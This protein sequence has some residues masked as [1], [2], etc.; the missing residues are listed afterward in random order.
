VCLRGSLAR[1]GLVKM[2]DRGEDNF[3]YPFSNSFFSVGD[4][5]QSIISSLNSRL[6]YAFQREN[7]Y[8]YR[9]RHIEIASDVNKQIQT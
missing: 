5:S 9:Y 6:D 1:S 7:A 8:M 4:S 2:V 3:T